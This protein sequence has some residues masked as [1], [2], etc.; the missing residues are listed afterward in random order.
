MV[1]TFKHTVVKFPMLRTPKLLGH[2]KSYD[3]TDCCHYYQFI[4]RLV[5]PLTQKYFSQP[6]S[7]TTVLFDSSS[8][9]SVIHCINGPHFAYC[10]AQTAESLPRVRQLLSRV[11]Q[12]QWLPVTDSGEPQRV[13][14]VSVKS[15]LLFPAGLARA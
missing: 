6:D 5:E 15:T 14:D 13:K 4:Y 11:R 9:L 12:V 10:T 1:Q 7:L 3:F 8:A 2:M